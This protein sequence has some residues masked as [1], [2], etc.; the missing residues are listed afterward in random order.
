MSS[1]HRFADWH[2]DGMTCAYT[3]RVIVGSVW[4]SRSATSFTGNP[5]G[6]QQAG[7]GVPQ[8]MQSQTPK[9]QALTVLCGLVPAADRSRLW[10]VTATA[11]AAV[12]GGRGRRSRSAQTT[13]VGPEGHNLGSKVPCVLQVAYQALT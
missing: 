8:I 3:L 11:V 9:S 13:P 1:D 7:M 5:G 2:M 6:E 4:P 10:L 12:G